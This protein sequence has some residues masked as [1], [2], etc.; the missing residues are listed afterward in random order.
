MNFIEM[1]NSSKG[2]MEMKLF[3]AILSA[4]FGTSDTP[5]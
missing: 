5:P 3:N 4:L 1:K 2:Q